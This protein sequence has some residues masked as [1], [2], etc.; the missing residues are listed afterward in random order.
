[1]KKNI[2]ES[3]ILI[4]LTAIGLLSCNCSD[5]ALRDAF[6][7]PDSKY[8]P[9]PF[10]FLNGEMTTDRIKE[11]LTNAKTLSGFGGVTPLPISGKKRWSDGGKNTPPTQPE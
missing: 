2:F 9:M 7:A 1:M 4:A 6:V 5:R 10:W 8:H 3:V 11:Q